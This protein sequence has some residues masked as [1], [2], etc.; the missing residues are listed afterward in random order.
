VHG[1]YAVAAGVS[2]V[3]ALDLDQTANAIAIAG[4]ANNALRVTRTGDL[5]HWK[6]LAYP[7]VAKEGTHAAP[8]ARAGITGTAQVFEGNKG[9][10]ETIA[11]EFA[12]DWAD[13]DLESVR[14]TI[15]KKHNA[16]IHA[17]SAIDAAIEIT[18]RPGFEPAAIRE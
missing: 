11:G 2:K 16:E 15:V 4:T 8:R 7:Q 12:I 18:E 10:K 3:L 1:A 14:R 9:F 17:Q 13:E 6:G 5:S